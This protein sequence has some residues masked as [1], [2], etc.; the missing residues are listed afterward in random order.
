MLLTLPWILSVYAG[1][2]DMNAEGVCVGYKQAAGKR[3][4]TG[5]SGCC[6][7]DGVTKNAWLMFLTSLS[8]FVIQ[9]PAYMVD[10]Q[11]TKAQL[12]KDYLAEVVKESKSENLWALVGLGVTIFFF[13]FYLYLQYLAAL[14]K[15]PPIACLKCLLPPAP[16]PMSMDLVRENGL[17]PLIDHYRQNHI[18]TGRLRVGAEV[19]IPYAD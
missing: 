11:K 5:A 1:Q 16:P 8:Y 3:K 12:G 7:N 9:I 19:A 18:N 2:V 10:D 6:Y 14:K 4:T 13:C 15:D 17:L